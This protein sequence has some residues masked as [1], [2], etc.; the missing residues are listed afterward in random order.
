MGK[1]LVLGKQIQRKK[2]AI[3]NQ[4]LEIIKQAMT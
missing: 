3:W 2:E 1:L 4:K